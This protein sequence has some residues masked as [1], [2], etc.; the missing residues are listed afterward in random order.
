ME[1]NGSVQREG[2]AVETILPRRL[3][4]RY[5]VITLNR[6]R[7]EKEG[8]GKGCVPLVQMYGTDVCHGKTMSPCPHVHII[9]W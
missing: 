6:L 2:T 9:R 4:T 8:E 3:G 1:T 7:A 5:V